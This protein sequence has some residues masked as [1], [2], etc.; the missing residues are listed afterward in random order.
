MSWLLYK[1]SNVGKKSLCQTDVSL[2]RYCTVDSNKLDDDIVTLSKMNLGR[3]VLKFTCVYTV[4]FKPIDIKR[5]DNVTG[6]NMRKRVPFSSLFL[7]NF[8]FLN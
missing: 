4:D 8:S 7:N 5:D 6:E 2:A 1:I 3:C